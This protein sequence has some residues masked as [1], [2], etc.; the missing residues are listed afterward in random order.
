MNRTQSRARGLAAALLIVAALAGVPA[1]L[2]ALGA[3]PWTV[4][5][6]DLRLSLLSPDDGSVAL[7]VIGATAWIAWAVMAFCLLTEIV[8]AVRGVRAP[9]LRG[10]GAGQQLASQLVA[11]A[12]VLF[13]IAQPL[14]I[15]LA[16]TPAHADSIT[17][18]QAPPPAASLAE[19]IDEATPPSVLPAKSAPAT[20]LYTTR[21]HDSLWKI[22]EAHLGDGTR[23]T[24]IVDLNPDLFPD[25]PGF[26]TAGTVLQ[27]PANESTAAVDPEDSHYV[28]EPGDTLWDIAD[29][30]LGDSTRYEEIF[31]ASDDIVQPD[32]QTLTDPDLIYPGWELEIPDDAPVEMRPHEATPK[33]STPEPPSET[34]PTAPPEAIP[35]PPPLDVESP[36]DTAAEEQSS[37]VDQASGT[38]TWLLPGLTG[39]GTVLAGSLFLV[40]RAHRRTQLRFRSPGEVIEP[41]PQE[42]VAVEKTARLSAGTVPRLQDLDR[43]LRH[44][45]DGLE[46][47]R[48]PRPR[49]QY[50]ELADQCVTLH[51]AGPAAPPPG[52]G[53]TDD[54]WTFERD[55][56]LPDPESPA[57]WPLLCTIGATADGH[58]VL[59]NLEELGTIALTGDPEAATALARSMTAELTLSPWSMLT[60]I[61]TVGVAS[62]LA[63]LDP[64]RHRH[65]EPNNLDFLDHLAADLANRGD[66]EPEVFHALITTDADAA[67]PIIRVITDSIERLGATVVTANHSPRAD[68]VSFRLTSDGRL[69]IPDLGLDLATAGLT[70][71]EAA[72]T[73]A[74]VAVTRDAAPAPPPANHAQEPAWRAVTDRSGRLVTAYADAPPA[75][76]ETVTVIGCADDGASEPEEETDTSL[77]EA[78]EVLDPTLDGDVAEWFDATSRVPKLHL[79][80]PVRATAHGNPS[81]V[82]RR[83]PHYVEL[84]TYLALHPEGVSSRQVAEAFSMSKDRV[85]ID[86]GVVRK[87]LGDNARTGRPHL[88]PAAQTR[89]ANEVGVWTYQVDDVLVDADLFR[90][91]RARGQA[92]GEEGRQDF[93]TALRLVEAAPFSELRETGWSWLLD[94]DSREDEI[95]ACAIVDVAHDV[96]AAAL[97]ADDL[98]QAE[99]AVEIARRASPYDEVARVDCAAVLVAQGH[100]DMAREFLIAAVHNRSDD[101]LGPIDVPA[102]TAEILAKRMAGRRSNG[103]G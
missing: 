28:V 30:E 24:E 96:V 35:A 60:D 55:R 9:Q 68:G 11:S 76:E 77:Q 6:A 19:P 37:D 47:T 78:V 16:A 54:A 84:L 95:L 10:L 33:D 99:R 101:H 70:V 66:N 17:E 5:L 59:A 91:L 7:I 36:T 64:V 29:E 67:E 49:L 40:L 82:A 86:M 63:D 62:E 80:G 38:P 34:A 46:L 97:S 61:D 3:T 83:K 27:L 53:G 90:R 45:A 2:V 100:E 12:A 73:A 1:L 103:N 15:T 21:A 74:I 89:A 94:A 102:R 71:A 48:Q 8:A 25:G 13:A 56:P 14:S 75:V 93:D 39:A 92:R 43:L 52:W 18:V 88:P 20:E 57:P 23:F 87:W 31:G 72:A 44:L 79:L 22:A 41:P 69:H 50:V 81:A 65:H 98:N 42:L 51:L 32:G 26:L 58:L 85:R 4:D